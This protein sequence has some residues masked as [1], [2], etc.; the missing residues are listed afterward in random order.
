VLFWVRFAVI[1]Q[2]FLRSKGILRTFVGCFTVKTQIF[3]HF[4]M[5]ID[6]IIVEGIANIG[7]SELEFGAM[8]ALIAPN[9]YGK[10]NMLRA[11]AFG[12]QFIKEGEAKREQM[13]GGKYLPV[14]LANLRK[15]FVFEISG[16]VVVAGVEQGFC[17]GYKAAWQTDKVRGR[18]LGEWLKIKEVSEKR[19]R[20]LVNRREESECLI[21]SSAKGRCSKPYAVADLQLALSAIAASGSLFYHE[22]AK[23]ICSIFIPN[24]ETLDNPE[25]YFSPETGRGIEIL[26]GR[27]L[28]EYLYYL[29]QTDE[30]N[31]SILVDGLR[32]LLPGVSEISAEAVTL[33]DGQSQLYDVRIKETHNAVAT[34]I[35]RLS[36]GSK[37]MIFLFTLCVAAQKQNIPM[38][39]MEEPENSV[40]PRL[41]ENLVDTLQVYAADTKILMTSHSPYLMRYM[42]PEQ[43]Y[44]GLPKN[45]GLVH[46]AKINPSKLKSLYKYAA[47][48]E[49]TIGEFMFDFMLDIEN[50]ADKISTFFE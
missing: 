46:F 29:K 31:Y 12:L 8:N 9:G 33:A 3:L 49:L 25:T 44:F 17:Y 28:S 34:S 40:H 37:R 4:G 21:V 27:T 13:L 45:D 18:I 24:I 42:R 15:D 35:S 2:I 7:H 48:M 22:F 19:Y 38:I 11:I 41:M 39:M 20:K 43:M 16:T 36:S 47:D 26:G 30:R 32:Q 6:R 50:D 10:S 5:S 1:T 14:N 23:Q